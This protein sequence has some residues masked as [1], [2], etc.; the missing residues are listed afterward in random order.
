VE[1]RGE[2]FADDNGMVTGDVSGVQ[3]ASNLA[4]DPFKQRNTVRGPEEADLVFGYF[5]FVRF[6]F[7]LGTREKF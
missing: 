5:P 2:D 3:A 7:L 4:K 6:L 1:L